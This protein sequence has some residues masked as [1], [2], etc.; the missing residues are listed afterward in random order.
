MNTGSP[1]DSRL[2]S[3]NR[4]RVVLARPSHPGNVG[5]AARAMKTMG[6]SRLVLVSPKEDHLCAESVARAANANDVLESAVVCENL[7]QA[8]EGTIFSAAMTARVR[9]L[10]LP[11][12]WAREGAINLHTN[13]LQGEVALVFGNEKAGLSN[14]EVSLCSQPVRI[15]VNPE[16]SSLNLGSA[17]QVMCYELRMAALEN[18]ITPGPVIER[19]LFSDIQHFHAHLE[20]ALL[21]SGFLNPDNPKRLI[22]RM[23]RLFDK[24]QLEPEEVRLLR[25]MLA[26]FEKSSQKLD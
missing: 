25:G 9:E 11:M 23:Q 2:N 24:A 5:A 18:D 20:K 13:S 15:P 4:V 1:Q 21:A 17:V 14:E 6:L 16:Y 19:A 26:S 7:S 12:V 8:L 3:L 10:A 22:P